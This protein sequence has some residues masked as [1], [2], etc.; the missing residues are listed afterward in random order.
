MR[1]SK[2]EYDDILTIWPQGW[3][4]T[5]LEKHGDFLKIGS[6]VSIIS[7]WIESICSSPLESLENILASPHL[8]SRAIVLLQEDLYQ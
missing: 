4:E 3:V 5:Y 7:P 6:Q 1:K 2:E 8:I